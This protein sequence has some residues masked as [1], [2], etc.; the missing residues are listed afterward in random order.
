MLASF[1]LLAAALIRFKAAGAAVGWGIQ[2]QQP[3]FLGRHGA[4]DHAVRRE[5]VGLAADRRCPAG[6]A[7]A[8]GCGARPRPLG[9]AFLLGAFATLLAARLL[10]ALPRHRA[11][12]RARARAARHRAGIRRAGPRHGRALSRWSPRLPGWSRGCRGRGRGW[13]AA[14][15]ARASP[16]S[17]PP[18]WLLFVLAPS[19]RAE[20]AALLAGAVL[21]V[22]LAVLAWRHRRPS[23]VGPRPSPPSPLPLAWCWCRHCAARPCRSP[24]PAPRPPACGGRSTSGAARAG[25]R[26]KDRVR[27][28]HRRLVPDLQGQRADGAGP[29]AGRRPAS[30]ARR[31][32][33]AR[34]LDPARPCRRR[35]SAKLRPLRRAVRRGLWT[36]RAGRHSAAR[37]VD[38][39]AR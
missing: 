3:W 32:R 23:A 8:T 6:F 2:F 35:L 5:P 36:R 30:L 27:R 14:A 25:R 11:R 1:G 29:G 38:V 19:K 7:G 16:C 13:L 20:R 18:V 4:A 31:R 9:D 17:A 26:R 39:A 33:D 15:R 28:R 34:R 37:T 22:L 10:G 21:A 12:L 24:A